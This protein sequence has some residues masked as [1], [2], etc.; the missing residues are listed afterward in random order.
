MQKLCKNYA[1]L[2][3]IMQQFAHF[4]HNFL[5]NYAKNYANYL[6]IFLIFID[7]W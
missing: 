5:H 1:K 6:K 7:K 3:K 4:L 2:C